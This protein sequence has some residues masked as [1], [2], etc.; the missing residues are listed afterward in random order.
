MNYINYV[1]GCAEAKIYTG[2]T[3]TKFEVQHAKFTKHEI[4]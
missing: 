2:Q 1:T 4:E 3:P